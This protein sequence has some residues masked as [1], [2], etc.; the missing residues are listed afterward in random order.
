MN[1]SRLKILLGVAVAVAAVLVWKWIAGWGLVT[2]DVDGATLAKVIR[3]IERQGGVTISSN[4]DPET[5]VTM[6]VHEVPAAEAIDYLAA[7]IDARW[8]VAYVAG[9][10]KEEVRGGVDALMAGGR[11]EEFTVFNYPTWGMGVD[12]E[13]VPDPR[14]IAWSVSASDEAVMASY[15]DQAAQKTGVTTVVP[16]AWNPA[17]A[18]TPASGEAGGAIVKLVKSSGGRVEEVFVLAESRRDWGRGGGDGQQAGSDNQ[19]RGGEGNGGQ[20]ASRQGGDRPERRERR[21]V[22]PKWAEERARAQIAMLPTAEQAE[23]KEAYESARDLFRRVRDLPQEERRAAM[24]AYFS[25]PKVQDRMEERRARR[26]EKQG[27]EKRADR[28]RRYVD[29]KAAAKNSPES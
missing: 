7:R 16:V 24:E 26:D 20:Q 18:R 4:V 3:S 11:N 19:N 15:L 25:D 14:E 1:S 22:N 6:A 28:Y 13:M 10:T 23:A 12:S 2:V 29:R 9:S 21:E 27:P 17:V 5:S 8:S